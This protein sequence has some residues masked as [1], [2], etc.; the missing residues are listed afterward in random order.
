MKPHQKEALLVLFSRPEWAMFI[1][2][3]K[4][5]LAKLHE[6]LEFKIGDDFRKAQGQIAEIRLDLS[7]QQTTS[8]WL[9]QNK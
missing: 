8:N 9:E 2:Y 1:E 4:E 6:E 7:L 3:K 5:R